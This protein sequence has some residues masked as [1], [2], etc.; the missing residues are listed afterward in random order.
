MTKMIRAIPE[1]RICKEIEAGRTYFSREDLIEML[2]DCEMAPEI[3]SIRLEE[4][5]HVMTVALDSEDCRTLAKNYIEQAIRAIG[6]FREIHAIDL[7]TAAIKQ[8]RFSLALKEQD[9]KHCE[10]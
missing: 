9:E 2:E 1:L 4:Y 7:L 10:K 3:N 6:N 5:F 8:L